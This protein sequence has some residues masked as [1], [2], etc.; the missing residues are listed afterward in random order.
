MLPISVALIRLYQKETEKKISRWKWAVPVMALVANL[1]LLLTLDSQSLM[2]GGI[3]VGAGAVVFLTYSNM[4]EKRG[5]AGLSI[6]LGEQSRSLLLLQ[7]GMK[8]LMPSANPRF[9][10]YLFDIAQTL[11][12]FDT[13]EIIVLNVIKTKKNES[14]REALASRDNTLKSISLLKGIKRFDTQPGI[15]VRPVV[16]AAKDLAAGISDAAKEERC[17][18]LIMGWSFD[19][20]GGPSSII[21]NVLSNLSIDAIFVAVKE[22]KPVKKIG[23]AV[24]SV[25]NLSLM[26]KVAGKLAEQYDATVTY[27]SVIPQ[28]FDK[29]HLRHARNVTGQALGWHH[30]LAICNT[31]ILVNDDPLDAVVTYSENLDLLIVGSVYT[32]LLSQGAVGE[33]SAL[34]IEK[35]HCSVIAVRQIKTITKMLSPS[36]ETF[37]NL[38]GKS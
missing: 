34:L 21:N 26:T 28:N 20:N 17:N 12:P 33:F 27:I 5:N 15:S 24:S 8:I 18:L 13:G 1:F 11:L 2:F 16:R 25:T 36:M 19:K 23:V 22:E 14:I 30:D 6:A 29:E 37:K 10:P 7:K 38:S 4:S 31:K 3:I 32:G 9:T 35:A